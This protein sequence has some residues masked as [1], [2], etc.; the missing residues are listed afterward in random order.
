[1]EVPIMIG[2][3]FW[4]RL[5]L[6]HKTAKNRSYTDNQY[7]TDIYRYFAP[8]LDLDHTDIYQYF[9]MSG[10]VL[11]RHLPALCCVWTWTTQTFTGTLPCLDLDHTQGVNSPSIYTCVKCDIVPKCSIFTIFHKH[12]RKKCNTWSDLPRTVLSVKSPIYRCRRHY[13]ALCIVL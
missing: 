10:L 13:S 5:K 12:G 8:C 3:S 1:M 7:L 2:N 4:L 6:C 11:H 9:A